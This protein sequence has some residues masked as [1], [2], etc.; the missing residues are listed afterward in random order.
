MTSQLGRSILFSDLNIYL[1]IVHVARSCDKLGS[2]LWNRVEESSIL[3]TK[4]KERLT[5]LVT[6]A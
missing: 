5:G 4:N 6:L 1:F 2:I 3:S